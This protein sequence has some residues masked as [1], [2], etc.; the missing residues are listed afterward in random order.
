MVTAGSV[1]AWEE[2]K[3]AFAVEFNAYCSVEPYLL[4]SRAIFTVQ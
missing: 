4:F 2:N 3:K 1:E